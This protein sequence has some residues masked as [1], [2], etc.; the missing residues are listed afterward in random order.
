MTTPLIPPSDAWTLWAVL[1][2]AA[3]GGIRL[4]QT[5][6]GRRVSGAVSTMLITFA[7]S[8]LRVIPADAPTYGVVWSFLVPLAIPLLLL[9]ADL[10]RILREAGPPLV[11]F[12]AGGVGTVLGTVLATLLLDLGP[13]EHKLA[14]VFCATYIGGSINYAGA[15]EALG[16]RD[17]TLLSAGVAADNLMMTVYFMVLFALPSWPWLRRQFRQRVKEGAVAGAMGGA[18]GGS[19]TISTATAALA[20]SAGA[21][22]VGFWFQ[23]VVGIKGAGILALTALTVT[24]ATVAPAVMGRLARAEVIGMVLMQVFF[25][26]IGASANIGMVLRVGPVLF[27]FAAVILSVHLAA[28]LLA[29]RL[30][31]LDLAEA[32]IASNANMGGP[33]TAAAMAAGRR[34]PGLVVPA[35][36]CGTL[37]YASA[38]FIGVAVGKLLA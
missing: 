13:E 11:A 8:N 22:A 27:L 5:G 37:G 19:V 38:T 4:E 32:V 10:R 36:L 34:W 24:A 1:A 3:W 35:I 28:V 16:L 30:F 7:L 20:L 18:G 29:A 6:L 33:T 12:A 15:A 2:L 25:A 17:G 9:R 23:G 31:R 21:C 26:V 14:G